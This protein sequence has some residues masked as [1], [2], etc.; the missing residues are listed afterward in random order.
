VVSGSW[1]CSDFSI[2]LFM[3]SGAGMFAGKLNVIEPPNFPDNGAPSSAEC[4]EGLGRG[5]GVN[6]DHNRIH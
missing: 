5:D 2:T 6:G 4:G 3:V 1:S